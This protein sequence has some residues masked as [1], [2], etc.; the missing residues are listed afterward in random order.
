MS[1]TTN[2]SPAPDIGSCLPALVGREGNLLPFRNTDGKLYIRAL[3]T[4]VPEARMDVISAVANG[5]YTSEQANKDGYESV[6]ISSE[7]AIEM[8]ALVAESAA[9]G[10]GL[11]GDDISVVTHSS[12]HDNG[13]GGF[14]QPAAFLQRRLKATDAM[15][16]SINH[17]CNGL[18]L[19][20]LS[21]ASLLGVRGGHGLAVAADRFS[22]SS[23]NRWNSD[24]G[25]VYGDA[26]TA[27]C[28][29]RDQGFARIVY[30]DFDSVPELEGMHRGE[31]DEHSDR[32][33]VSA[34]KLWFL[35]L[36][37]KSVFFDQMGAA[38]TRLTS[39]LAAAG[40]AKAGGYSAVVIP[41]VGRTI[42]AGLYEPAFAP[43]ARRTMTA[44]GKTI[45]HTGPSDQMIG[46]GRY[47]SENRA[48]AGDRILLFGV[49]AGFSLSLTVVEL[50]RQ[51]SRWEGSVETFF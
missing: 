25:I 50:C 10:A 29:S 42:A 36:H 33:D 46:L 1:T 47:L 3:A 7:P 2:K 34:R 51:P 27:V 49:G 20:M 41:F 31:P 21:N 15:S 35:S 48:M 26:A 23:F 45:G 22:G 11:T 37:G 18:M 19:A 6:A 30:M 40:L 17:G 32:W 5:S 12:I 13:I 39:R 24:A 16:L 44:F 38:V 43:F 4:F 9:S 28:L 14:W 8:A